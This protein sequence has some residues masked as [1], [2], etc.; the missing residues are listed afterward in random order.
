MKTLIVSI[1]DNFSQI[2]AI[3]EKNVKLQTRKKL[4]LIVTLITPI[5]GVIVPLIILG[6]IFDL[7][8][9]FGPWNGENY[10]VF[11]FTAYQILLIYAII[12]RFQGDIA[13]EKGMNTFTLLELAPFRRINLLSGIFLSHLVLIGI[14]FMIF[15]VICYILYPVSIITLFFI[16]L[17]YFLITL[18]FSGVGL[19]FAVF[20]ISKPSLVPLLNVPLY[21]LGMFSCLSMPF[22]FFPEYFQDI[23]SLNPLYYI[24]VIIRYIWVE[25][26]IIL[27]IITHLD[28]FLIVLSLA[29]A[30]PLIG[31]KFFN[32]FFN[33]Y[34]IIIY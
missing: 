29:I 3:A 33:R 28:T 8:G 12:S 1:K 16:F 24:F 31:I 25:N 17:T 7:A 27:S 30:A 21:I 11:Q 19:I 23:A 32:Y 22:D 5:L 26:N 10:V 20:V 13:T 6:K 2:Y 18:I 15:F 14:P 4:P 34:R 9:N